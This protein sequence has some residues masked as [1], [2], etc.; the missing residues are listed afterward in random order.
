MKAR[1][2]W[3]DGGGMVKEL[4]V[5]AWWKDGREMEEGWVDRCWRGGGG[6]MGRWWWDRR[7]TV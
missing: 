6:M 1:W 5:E 4:M 2:R 3:R 7:R